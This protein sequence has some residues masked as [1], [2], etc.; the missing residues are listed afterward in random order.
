M[1]CFRSFFKCCSRVV[2][3]GGSRGSSLGH[4]PPQTAVAP[5]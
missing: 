2:H 1:T 5:P 3:S 4:F